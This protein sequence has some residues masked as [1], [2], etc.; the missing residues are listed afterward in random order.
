MQ[1]NFSPCLKKSALLLFNAFLQIGRTGNGAKL[2]A[3]LGEDRA[4]GS[5]R[6]EVTPNILLFPETL[7]TK[8][9]WLFL[10]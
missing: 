6:L 3:R 4:C 5:W 7:N 9:F 2:Y 8:Y 1:Y 10:F